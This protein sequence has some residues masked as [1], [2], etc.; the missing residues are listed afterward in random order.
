M[1]KRI[2]KKKKIAKSLNENHLHPYDWK[3]TSVSWRTI[4]SQH[5]FIVQEYKC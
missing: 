3:L 2:T 5:L 4:P 1:M